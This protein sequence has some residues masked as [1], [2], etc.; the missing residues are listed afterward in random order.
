MPSP[1]SIPCGPR[2]CAL[3]ITR[4]LCSFLIARQNGGVIRRCRFLRCNRLPQL[5]YMP[6]IL[7]SVRLF[8]LF[9]AS[10]LSYASLAHVLSR[11]RKSV[12]SVLIFNAPASESLPI[13]LPLPLQTL[14]TLREEL[15]RA[16]TVQGLASTGDV[17][18]SRRDSKKSPLSKKLSDD[19]ISLLC[20][21]KNESVVPRSLLK[22]GK[23]GKDYLERSRLAEQ[24]QA[25]SQ[26]PPPP[27]LTSTSQVHQQQG[28]PPTSLSDSVRFSSLMKDFNLL[29]NDVNDPK[30]RYY[31]ASPSEHVHHRTQHLSCQSILPQSSHT[32]KYR[33]LRVMQ[34]TALPCFTCDGDQCFLTQSQRFVCLMPCSPLIPLHIWS[35]YGKTAYLEFPLPQIQPHPC[36]LSVTTLSA[37]PAGIAEA[38]TTVSRTFR[39]C[40][41]LE[42]IFLYSKSI[43]SGPLR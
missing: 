23:R 36:P 38:F 16:A 14:L 25:I 7:I 11:W 17:L 3:R 34:T 15:L 10:S 28:P 31:N 21:P 9:S 35:V 30:E 18:V 24:E 20:C 2:D 32:S 42:R 41:P 33:S 12:N 40:Y 27:L 4:A 43:G 29:R 37:L 39:N 8:F 5:N 26:A 1:R 13:L 22:K 19:I 6:M